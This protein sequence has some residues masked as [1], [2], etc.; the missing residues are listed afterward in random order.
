MHK[1]KK[2][3]FI[4]DIVLISTLYIIIILNVGLLVSDNDRC[5]ECNVKMYIM[6]SVKPVGCPRTS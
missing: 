5:H 2:Y 4:H 3:H 6:L 1:K